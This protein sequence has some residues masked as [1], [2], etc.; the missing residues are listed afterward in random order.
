MNGLTLA[1]KVWKALES[2]EDLL[3]MRLIL[4]DFASEG[5]TPAEAEAELERM[6]I[7]LRDEA[8]ED[9]ILEL[10]DIVHSYCSVPLQV[11]PPTP[12]RR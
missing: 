6:R 1:D 9:R 4:V 2:K 3:S 7:G 5:G 12:P 10:L 8:K 11:W